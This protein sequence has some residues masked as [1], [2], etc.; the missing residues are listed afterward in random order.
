MSGDPTASSLQ[1]SARFLQ[2][3]G[4]ADVPLDTSRRLLPSCLAGYAAAFQPANEIS[5]FDQAIDF[6][7]SLTFPPSRHVV[8]EANGITV[9]VNNSRNGSDYADYV[10]HLPKHLNCRF[11]RVVDSRARTCKTGDLRMTLGYTARIFDL[12]DADGETI[13]SVTCM[14]DGGRRVFQT[15]GD[16]HEIE[17]SFPYEA[18]RKLDR[19][20]SDHLRQLASAFDLV[21]PTINEFQ[22]AG[23]YLLFEQ[24]YR[25]DLTSCTIAEADDPAYAYY[26]RGMSYVPHMK[27]HATSV[28]ADFER[29]VEWNPEFEPRVRKYLDDARK[30]LKNEY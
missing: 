25:K 28:I 17:A 13:R 14:N 10:V 8:F 29:C 11:A 18:K 7:S 21:I 22:A 5:D 24:E 26:T 1:L 19:F 12:H 30:E 6:L 3:V 4:L 15:S 20:T 16:P 9:F 2:G 27:T 23:C